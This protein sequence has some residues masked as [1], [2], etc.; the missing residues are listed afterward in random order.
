M[1]DNYTI[2]V[3][4]DI[5]E[6]DKFSEM[7]KSRWVVNTDGSSYVTTG[8]VTIPSLTIAAAPLPAV[9]PGPA[10]TVQMVAD[11]HGNRTISRDDRCT[12]C[13]KAL[14]ESDAVIRTVHTDPYVVSATHRRCME[15][16]LE[17]TP[18]WDASVAQKKFDAYRAELLERGQAQS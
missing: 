15:K 11:Q 9:K 18:I 14:Q 12:V 4:L 7:D 6:M 8:S 5:S 2:G 13:R 16:L 3:N 1:T 10:V 17:D